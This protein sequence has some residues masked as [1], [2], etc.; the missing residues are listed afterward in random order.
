MRNKDKR[1]Y[2]LE[3]YAKQIEALP[4]VSSDGMEFH[5][6]DAYICPLCLRAFA[7]GNENAQTLKTCTTRI[8]RE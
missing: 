5:I 2:I 8:S 6:T 4:F 1:N 3:I 7:I